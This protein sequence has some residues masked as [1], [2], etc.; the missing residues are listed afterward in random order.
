MCCQN[1]E[2]LLFKIFCAP[3]DLILVSAAQVPSPFYIPVPVLPYGT[4]YMGNQA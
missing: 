1:T 2:I 4:S 3:R